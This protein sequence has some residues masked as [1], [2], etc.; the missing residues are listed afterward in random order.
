MK[1]FY[2]ADRNLSLTAGQ[3][4]VVN[5][6]GLSPFGSVYWSHIQSEPPPGSDEAVIREY[7]A[8]Q[9]LHMVGFLWSRHCCVFAAETI[10][11]AVA[12]ARAI[13]PVPDHPVPIYEIF[14]DR[15][16]KHDMTWLDYRVDVDRLI[17]YCCEY[18]RGTASNH[19]PISGPRKPPQWEI[20]IP[21]PAQVGRLVATV[22]V[23]N[24]P[25]TKK[26]IQALG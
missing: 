18:W 1:T 3:E 11:E 26:L 24:G 17:Q 16:S 23:S 14:A 20:L 5:E 21:L 22:K 25:G 8:E 4:L 12:F 6:R 2:H 10:Q 9:A 13:L 7:C 19:Q 15:A